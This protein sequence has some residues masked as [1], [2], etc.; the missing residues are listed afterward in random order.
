MGI[1]KFADLCIVAKDSVSLLPEVLDTPTQ[2]LCSHLLN[3]ATIASGLIEHVWIGVAKL[4][5]LFIS[6]QCETKSDLY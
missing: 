3:L 1:L 2:V 5:D 4:A 6:R